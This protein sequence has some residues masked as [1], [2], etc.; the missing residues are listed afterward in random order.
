MSEE[1]T[2]WNLPSY[3]VTRMSTTGNPA[4]RPSSMALRTPFS[5]E[6]MNWLGTDP[7]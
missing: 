3:R 7:P 6:G 4:A 5:T 1:S 2:E